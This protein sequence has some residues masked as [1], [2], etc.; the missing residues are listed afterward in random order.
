MIIHSVCFHLSKINLG[1][2]HT[3]DRLNSGGLKD[4]SLATVVTVKSNSGQRRLGFVFGIIEETTWNCLH[5]RNKT[6]G[7]ET[8][9]LKAAAAE[10][11]LQPGVGW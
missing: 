3:A 11:V 9:L 5:I 10:E 6:I 1:A 2:V 4:W 7:I 8:S